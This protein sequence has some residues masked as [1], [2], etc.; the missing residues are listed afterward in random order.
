MKA[1]TLTSSLI[2]ALSLTALGQNQATLRSQISTKEK[3][4]AE[5]QNELHELRS[6]LSAPTSGSHTVKSGESL[7]SIARCHK[8]SIADVIRW[9]KITYPARLAV[10]EKLI[11]S[12]S[13]T[14]SAPVTSTNGKPA[15]PSSKNTDYVIAKG[16]TFYSIARRHKLTLAQLRALNPNVSTHLLAP[17]KKLRVSGKAPVAS[18]TSSRKKVV[19]VQETKKPEVKKSTPKPP[20]P[21]ISAK[22][23]PKPAE[24]IARQPAPEKLPEPPVLDERPSSSTT[25]SIILTDVV[26]F[27]AFASKHGTSTEHLNALNGWNL[28]KSTVLAGGSEILV[29]N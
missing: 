10:G 13:G 25:K 12:G 23:T 24:T 2:T 16:D 8:V 18:S 6:K 3:Q 28:P 21:T 9:N 14:T 27:E 19:V 11:V 5:I 29:P 17:G 20:A 15:A 4:L 7:Y 1:L 26:T 22:Q